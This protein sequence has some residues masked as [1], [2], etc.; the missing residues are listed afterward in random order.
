[1][2]N[3]NRQLKRVFGVAC[4]I[5]VDGDD[6][7]VTVERSRDG[8]PIGELRCVSHSSLSPVREVK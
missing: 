4:R 2:T 5:D 7:H 1:M 6:I 3:Q 8:F